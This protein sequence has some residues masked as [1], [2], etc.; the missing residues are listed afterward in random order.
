MA[1]LMPGITT[2]QELAKANSSKENESWA[3]LKL[4]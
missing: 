4:P 3:Q 2:H 1:G